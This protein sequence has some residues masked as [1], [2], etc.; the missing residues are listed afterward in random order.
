MSGV[1]TV[2][3]GGVITTGAVTMVQLKAGASHGIEILRV[4][5]TQSLSETSTQERIQIVRKSAAATVTSATPLLM[6]PGDGVADSVGGV[7]ATGITATVEGTDGDIL[8]DAGFNILN[9]FEWLPT[10][11]ET[12][13]VEAA[14]IIGVKFPVAPA[15]A[16]FIATMYYRET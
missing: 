16:T 1:Y 9:G 8:V 6:N 13:V 4:M 14:G 2:S 3:N 15:S 11:L 7:A 12:I 5:V 10:P